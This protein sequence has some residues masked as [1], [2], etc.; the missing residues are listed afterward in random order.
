MKHGFGMSPTT[1]ISPDNRLAAVAGTPAGD[2]AHHP[3]PCVVIY[4]LAS[5]KPVETLVGPPRFPAKA[6]FSPDGKTLAVG[7][8]GAVQLFNVGDIIETGWGR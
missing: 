3:Q 5:G 1:A 7:G 4:D 6:A 2:A 8:S